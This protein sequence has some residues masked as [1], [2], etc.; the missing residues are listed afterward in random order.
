MRGNRSAAMLR[1]LASGGL[2]GI[3]AQLYNDFE[4]TAE[5]AHPVIK[6][7]KQAMLAFGAR[8]ALMSGS[9]PTVFG[10]FASAGALARA[11]AM[12]A[13]QFPSFVVQRG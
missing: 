4:L 13:R 1:A 12:I 7:V 5:R 2:D 6:E 3:A 11:R 8:G 10:L 9:G